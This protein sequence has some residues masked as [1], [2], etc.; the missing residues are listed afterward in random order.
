MTWR[1]LG[2]VAA[3]ALMMA[4][5]QASAADVE[6]SDETDWTG[7]YIGV[8]AGY[9][10]ASYEGGF[11]LDPSDDTEAFAKDLKLDGLLGGAHIGYNFHQSGNV[12]FGLEA[13]IT[14]MDASDSLIADNVTTDRVQSESINGSVDLLASVRGRLGYTAGDS[15]FF[16]TGGVAFADADYGLKRDASDAFSDSVNLGDIG[17]VGGLGFE[18]AMTETVNIRLEG[19]YYYFHD[20]EFEP[21][22]GDCGS[23]CGR[24]LDGDFVRFEDVIV[25][26]VGVSLE[27]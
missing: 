1:I 23:D 16:V 18:F 19:L 20:K 22:G 15:L 21:F 10:E 3:V 17:V 25:G 13:D 5:G 9:G 11:R 12:L 26:R 2:G 27:L 4:G 8:H 6:L 14:L 7:F 24:S